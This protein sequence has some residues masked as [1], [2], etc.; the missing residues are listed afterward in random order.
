MP[1]VDEV[2][3]PIAALS[4]LIANL[5]RPGPFSFEASLL[6]VV[7]NPI[8]PL[9]ECVELLLLLSEGSLAGEDARLALVFF[10]LVGPLQVS[11][12][13]VAS[14]WRGHEASSFLRLIGVQAGL[15][16]GIA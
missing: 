3:R 4:D 12:S 5:P 9:N 14:L 15:H 8:E 11:P 7:I 1:W 6:N 10:F 13:I 2:L 16:R